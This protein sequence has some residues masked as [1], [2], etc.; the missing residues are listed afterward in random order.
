MD[1]PVSF[2]S[3]IRTVEVTGTVATTGGS[4]GG[5]APAPAPTYQVRDSRTTNIQM[6][7]GGTGTSGIVIAPPFATKAGDLLVCFIGQ[8]DSTRPY[9][10]TPSGWTREATSPL[11]PVYFKQATVDGADSANAMS[12]A[13]PFSGFNY[14]S[15]VMVAVCATAGAAPTKVVLNALSQEAAGPAASPQTAKDELVL[16]A[17]SS[18]NGGG[19]GADPGT[20]T[21]MTEAQGGPP[22]P[23]PGIGGWGGVYNTGGGGNFGFLRVASYVANWAGG[24]KQYQVNWPMVGPGYT[25]GLKVVA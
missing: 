16:L 4:G 6:T 24:L 3:S 23:Q 25:A 20:F 19:S 13:Y 14:S 17:T 11:L 8:P 21:W 9:P 10:G 22:A 15:A 12:V 7:S 5:T 18:G 1:R 2:R